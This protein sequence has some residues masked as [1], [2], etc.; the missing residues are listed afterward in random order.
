M[1]FVVR[2]IA[3]V[4]PYE[5]AL[6]FEKLLWRVCRGNILFRQAQITEELLENAD[7]VIIFTIIIYFLLFFY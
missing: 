3:G 7:T 4:V 5:R 2:F 1:N 6:I